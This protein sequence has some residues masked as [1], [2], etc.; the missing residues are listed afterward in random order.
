MEGKAGELGLGE[1]KGF[2][3][4]EPAQF[5]IKKWYNMWNE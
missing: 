1:D 3:C 5:L 4:R 2:L